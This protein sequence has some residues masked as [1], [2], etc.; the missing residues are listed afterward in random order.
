MFQ[1]SASDS[2][3]KFRF[4]NSDI[5]QI[6]TKL[7]G[8][9]KIPISKFDGKKQTNGVIGNGWSA[10]R[11]LKHFFFVLASTSEA[12]SYKKQIQKKKWNQ[13][14]NFTIPDGCHRLRN[15]TDGGRHE[16]TPH[17]SWPTFVYIYKYMAIFGLP[18]VF[19]FYLNQ[20]RPPFQSNR[21]IQIHIFG[22]KMENIIIVLWRGRLVQSKVRYFW[23][24]FFS[25]FFT[26]CQ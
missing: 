26:S 23:G 17:A 1:I 3:L 2:N 20:P 12:I 25:F 22:A 7:I 10:G 9:T 16:G 15:W 24:E 14:V 8:R 18:F 6:F 13:P 19:S 4:Q 5:S 21:Y 11:N